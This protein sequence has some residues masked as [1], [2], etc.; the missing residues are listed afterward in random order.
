MTVQTRMMKIFLARQNA[1]HVP[2]ATG[3]QLQVLPSIE[4]LPRCQKHQFAAFIQDRQILIVWDDEPNSLLDRA[5]RIEESLMKMIWGEGEQ[6]YEKPEEKKSANV[7]MT[8]LPDGTVTPSELEEA[9]IKE[10]RPT[11][12][13]NSVFVG[14]TLTLLVAALGSGW[15]NL[16]IEVSADRSYTRLALLAVTPCQ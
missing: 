14:L 10:N 11:K 5:A 16:A 7:S 15:R 3:L 12:L 1:S 13:L 9:L 2:L 4:Y 8:E 6:L